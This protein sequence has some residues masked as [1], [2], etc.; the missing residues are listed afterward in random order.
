M[1][2]PEGFFTGTFQAGFAERISTAESGVHSSF[3]SL[4]I[5]WLSVALIFVVSIIP[6]M[7]SLK[8]FSIKSTIKKESSINAQFISISL[9]N[10]SL[11]FSLKI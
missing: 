8:R 2:F 5:I 1:I 10:F 9:V 7:L 6:I 4:K 3:I 11:S